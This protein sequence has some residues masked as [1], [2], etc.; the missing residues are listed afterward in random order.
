MNRL[1]LLKN[2]ENRQQ[3]KEFLENNNISEGKKFKAQIKTLNLDLNNVEIDI[4]NNHR[5]DW[6]VVNIYWENTICNYKELG[7]YGSYRSDYYHINFD[8]K[9]N[10][11]IIF[12]DK[13]KIQISYTTN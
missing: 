2:A 8:L 4:D 10:I 1:E 5:S 13:T 6:G 7:L 12:S 9:N 11:L 3:L